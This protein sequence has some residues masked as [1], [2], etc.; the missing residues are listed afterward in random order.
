MRIWFIDP[1]ILGQMGEP[2]AIP[3]ILGNML[4]AK[5]T[6]SQ[7]TTLTSPV[8]CRIMELK[9]FFEHESVSHCDTAC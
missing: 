1:S 9:D 8:S 2:C 5:L 4:K 7:E 6:H 3:V